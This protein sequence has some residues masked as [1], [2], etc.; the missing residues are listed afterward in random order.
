MLC[1]DGESDSSEFAICCAYQICSFLSEVSC[2]V[3]VSSDP[4]DSWEKPLWIHQTAEYNLLNK[5][6]QPC[7]NTWSADIS[8]IANVGW[9][10]AVVVLRKDALEYF[11]A[12]FWGSS[13]KVVAA[14]TSPTS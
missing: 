3:F 6:I 11:L 9:L 2:S 7:S 1:C 12:T 5:A 14:A 8:Y 13:R 4:P 10:R